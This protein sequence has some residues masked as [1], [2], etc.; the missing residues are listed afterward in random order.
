MA[1]FDLFEQLLS[2]VTVVAAEPPWPLVAVDAPVPVAV[3][4]PPV[5]VAAVAFEAVVSAS[6]TG[7]S[8][9]IDGPRGLAASFADWAVLRGRPS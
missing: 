3:V 6:G 4:V 7:E 1:V 5:A 2:M 8:G 9:D